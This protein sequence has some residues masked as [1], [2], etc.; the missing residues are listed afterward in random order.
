MR[1]IQIIFLLLLLTASVSYSQVSVPF[2]NKN[3]AYMGRVEIVNNEC[4]RIFWP[5]TSATLNFEGTSVSATL[6]NENGPAYFY[7]IID[8]NGE[9]A[10][11]INPENTKSNIELVS[12]LPEGKH[13]VQLFKLTDNTTI[14]DFYGFELND[15]AEVLKPDPLKKRKIEFYG[16]SITAGHGVDVPPGQND[17]GDPKYFNNYLTY[18]AR[19]ARHYNAQY[20]CIARSGIGIM[21]SWFPAIMPEIYNRLNPGDPNSKWDFSKYTPDLVVINLFQNDSWIVNAPQNDQFKARF[22]TT[23][24]DENKIIKAYQ[25]FVMKIRKEYPKASIICTLGSMDITQQG[26]PWPGYVEKAVKGLNDSKIY[27]HFMP[28]KNTPGHPKVMEQK[29]MADDLIQ[30]IDQNIKW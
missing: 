26:S 24:P 1:K 29:V 21:V 8:G 18:A 7:V 17:S 20:S 30:F 6:K 23:K 10:K 2:N 19:I 5:G 12:G 27:T 14:T 4:A 16:N 25:D 13:S 11:K 3:I 15:G 9:N 22:G 28:Y